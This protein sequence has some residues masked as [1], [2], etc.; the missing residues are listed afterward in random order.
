KKIVG[1]LLEEKEKLEW[2]FEQDMDKEEEI[3]E[4][5]EDDGEVW[6]LGD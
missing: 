5:D 2:W 3:F 6:K 1:K 4:G